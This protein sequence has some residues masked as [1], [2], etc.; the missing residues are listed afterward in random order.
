MLIVEILCLIRVK[1]T[2]HNI[3][4][5]KEAQIMKKLA[6]LIS[7]TLMMSSTAMAGDIYLGAKAGKS[8][9][10]DACVT[11]NACDDDSHGYGAY[12]GYQAWDNVALELGYDDFGKFTGEG[13]DN[14]KASAITLAPKFSLPVN[15]V[16]DFFGKIGVA[17]VDYGDET[18]P[19]MLGAFGVD[20]HATDNL[21]V[22][23][24]YQTLTDVNN[25][26]VRADV[27]QTS[28]GLSYKF[29]GSDPVVV[30]EAPVVE[31]VV[32]AQPEPVVEVVEVVKKK[33]NMQLDSSS[34]FATASS[35]LS[36]E[37]KKE[38]ETVVALL[39]KYPQATVTITGHTDSRGSEAF[40]QKLS[41][42]RA[43]AV[44]DEVIAQGIDA[45]RVTS[46]GKGELAPI[47]T[48]DTE[49]GR[50]MNRRVEIDV[51]TF[52]YEAE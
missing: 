46:M 49:A 12:L 33:L 1:V 13:M 3:D 14:E 27:N 17:Q 47:A 10:E 29:G 52:E 23:L 15:D 43:K 9:T 39:K 20:V 4:N 32:E 45:S 48:N 2:N 34:S 18:D 38:V 40:N 37:G 25:D 28:I 16:F 22:R 50:E 6:A 7:A 36:L 5:K 41:E 19:S 42:Q 35:E 11:G 8:W 24:E 26:I 31:P 44:A 21:S 51:P 30:E